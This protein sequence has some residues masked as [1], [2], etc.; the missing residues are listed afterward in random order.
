M[1]AGRTFGQLAQILPTSQMRPIPSLD[2]GNP[3]V[4]I[5]PD[6]ELAAKAGL[7]TEQIGV[8]VDVL[9]DGRKI[10]DFKFEGE[11]IDLTVEGDESFV[12]KSQDF[13]GLH[14]ATSNGRLVT[15]GSVARIEDAAGPEQINHVERRRT[16]TISIVPPDDVP[17]ETAIRTIRE[18][19]VA[20]LTAQGEIGGL[21]RMRLAGTADDL[22]VTLRALRGEF[23]LAIVISYLLMSALFE[24]FLY[25]FVIMFSVPLAAV[26]GFLG[27][28]L[29]NL[30]VSQPMDTLTMLGFI[31][32]IGTVVNNAI[33]IVHQALNLIRR[34]SLEPVDAIRESVRS[35]I[36]PIFMSTTTSV[37]G[38]LPLVIFP[39]AGSEL[40]RGIGSV[41]IGGL[42]VSTLFTLVVVPTLFSLV[43]TARARVKAAAVAIGGG[44]G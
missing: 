44:G 23:I 25:P 14:L 19:V 33:L 40:Y 18:E 13:A 21:Y 26:G 31:I 16:I 30:F 28:A 2:L 39:G 36:R 34:E 4:S 5:I 42:T 15:L 11:E 10:D 9:L 38:M 29:M 35:R 27:L 7:T 8:A 22:E 43:M 32:L 20:P 37:L 6:R 24:S 3:E 12:A 41:V 1:L 17:L